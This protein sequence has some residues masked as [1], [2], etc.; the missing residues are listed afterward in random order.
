MPTEQPILGLRTGERISA[1]RDKVRLNEL[2]RWTKERKP[3]TLDGI[4]ASL[5]DAIGA[6]IP[7][8][9]LIE[10]GLSDL[11]WTQVWH[12][13]AMTALYLGFGQEQ[14]D[15]Q[16]YSQAEGVIALHARDHVV[17]EP[18]LENGY[19]IKP[20]SLEIS[21]VQTDTAGTKRIVHGRYS[22]TTL[23][24]YLRYVSFDGDEHLMQ[25]RN[26]NFTQDDLRVQKMPKEGII[27]ETR[28]PRI[29]IVYPL[30][31][32]RMFDLAGQDFLAD[33]GP[34][35]SYIRDHHRTITGH[36]FVTKVGEGPVKAWSIMLPKVLEIAA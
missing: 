28:S 22:P 25:P 32:E 34:R 5:T 15:E 8:D 35:Q 10:S 7:I 36:E 4:N 24:A 23:Q 13:N 26:F 31:T 30:V 16:N 18:L 12:K 3:A 17:A 9:F 21:S 2:I 33:A 27:A 29:A 20:D 19:V 14:P 11:R 1:V 6:Q